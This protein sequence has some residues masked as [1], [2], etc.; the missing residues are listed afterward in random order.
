LNG[1]LI[2]ALLFAGLLPACTYHGLSLPKGVYLQNC[3]YGVLSQSQPARCLTRTEYLAE[4]EKARHPL[5][6]KT[7]EDAKPVDPRYKDWIP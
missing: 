4:K 1:R 3:T 7:Q 6:D 2:V 5:E